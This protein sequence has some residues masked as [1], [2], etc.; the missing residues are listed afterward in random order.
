MDVVNIITS[1][2]FPICA[3]LGMG[4][5][6]K[7]ITDMHEKA[8]KEETEKHSEEIARMTDALNNNTLALTIL[9]ENLKTE[10]E[11]TNK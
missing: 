7:Y 11:E 10:R 9:T 8:R 4:W 5:Y 2:G 3:C 6:V 1:V